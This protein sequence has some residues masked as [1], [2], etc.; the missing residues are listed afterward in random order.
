M[1]KSI[2]LLLLVGSC[3]LALSAC[4]SGS[5]SGGAGVSSSSSGS[6]S[7]SA[8]AAC[9]DFPVQLTPS[10][11][12]LSCSTSANGGRTASFDTPESVDL[13]VRFYQSQEGHGWVAD[14]VEVNTPEH[15]VV[16]LKK[17]P[18][19]A[20]ITINKGPQG[21]SVQINCYPNG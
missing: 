1:K 18:G 11:T 7:G 5:G 10:P 19:Y 16:T 8:D 13:V 6:T 9:K 20:T 21:S 12:N 2:A 15:A 17:A 3:C 4:S 14:P